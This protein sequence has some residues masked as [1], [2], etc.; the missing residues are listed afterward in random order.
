MFWEHWFD[1]ACVVKMLECILSEESVVRKSNI[2]NGLCAMLGR[3][4]GLHL[5]GLLST[6]MREGSSILKTIIDTSGRI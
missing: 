6:L 2:N 3:E 4:L 1:F 5:I